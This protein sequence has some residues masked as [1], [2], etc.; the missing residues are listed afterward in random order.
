METDTIVELA[1]KNVSLRFFT[2]DEADV[3]SEYGDYSIELS[4]EERLDLDFIKT[5]KRRL[6]LEYSTVVID[7][8]GDETIVEFIGEDE[9][10]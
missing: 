7:N 4:T 9:D 5:L 1:K 2:L 6:P 3:L 10:E 8:Y